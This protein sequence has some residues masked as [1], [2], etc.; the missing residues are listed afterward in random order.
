MSPTPAPMVYM[1]NQATTP[2]DER[3]L[4]AMWPYFREQCGNAA[5]RSH[6]YGWAAEDAVAQARQEVAA[7]IGARPKDIVFT[8]GA[9]ESDNLAIKGVVE[10]YQ[11][12]GNHV[13]TCVTEHK[14]VLDTCQ[15]LERAGRARVTYLPVDADGRVDPEDVR[16]ALTDQTI[17][18]SIMAANNEVGTLQPI[19]EIGRIAKAKGVLFHCDATQAAGTVPIDIARDG[20]DLLSMSA[21][22]MYGPKGCGPSTSAGRIRVCASFR[23][24]TAAATS[25]AC[26][27]ARSTCPASSGSARRASCAASSSTPKPAGCAPCVRCCSTR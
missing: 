14:A 6:A 10:A 25:A 12:L 24:W 13:V 19:R 22:K 23:R 9:T 21:H 8:S 27:R 20:L 11:D 7:L 2:V 18:V 17:L 5:S 15:S 1:D 4:A 26:A 16:H 3:V